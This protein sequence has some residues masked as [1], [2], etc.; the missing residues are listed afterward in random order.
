MNIYKTEVIQT[1]MTRRGAWTHRGRVSGNW[2]YCNIVFCQRCVF[3]LATLLHVYN[4]TYAY[5]C[6]YIYSSTYMS[7]RG[8]PL[9]SRLLF[10]GFVWQ[11]DHACFNFPVTK[12]NT[13]ANSS[14]WW[15]HALSPLHPV[16]VRLWPST[17][18]HLYQTQ[19]H[20]LWSRRI[21]TFDYMFDSID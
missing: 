3:E 5:S 2:S 17:T 18:E 6:M 13:L 11:D 21:W 16:P 15:A 4:V 10:S 9:R 8:Y 1:T 19:C 7:R 20:L 14:S 12:L